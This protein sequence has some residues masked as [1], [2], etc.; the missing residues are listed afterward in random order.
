MA[1]LNRGKRITVIELSY[2]LSHKKMHLSSL[3]WS[4]FGENCR[5]C[6]ILEAKKQN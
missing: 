1:G 5:T 2:A 3:R 6:E 4:Y